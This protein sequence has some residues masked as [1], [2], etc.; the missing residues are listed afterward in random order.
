MSDPALILVS[1]LPIAG[2]ALGWLM[3]RHSRSH[4]R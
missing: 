1:V 4:L 2:F 3:G